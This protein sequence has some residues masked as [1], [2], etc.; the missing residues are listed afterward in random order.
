MQKRNS[1][2]FDYICVQLRKNYQHIPTK[3][4]GLR[5]YTENTK[6]VKVNQNWFE[7]VVRRR[8]LGFDYE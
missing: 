7:F 4:I 6:E 5:T 8:S 2:R 1:S 3:T